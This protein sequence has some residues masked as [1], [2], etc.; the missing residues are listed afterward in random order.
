MC[1]LHAAYRKLAMQH[2]PVSESPSRVSCCGCKARH[3]CLPSLSPVAVPRGG[4]AVVRLCACKHGI[5]HMVA[6]MFDRLTCP[7]PLAVCWWLCRT[8]T[9]TTERRQKPSSKR[10]PRRTRYEPGGQAHA[11]ALESVPSPILVTS[12]FS[13]QH[14]VV[15]IFAQHNTRACQA[16]VPNC[17]LS[18]LLMPLRLG[19]VR[20]PK[21]RGV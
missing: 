5:G 21:A 14:V 20:P 19:T 10:Y 2:H 7:A 1:P 17:M 18:V 3:W 12:F 16:G 9:L 11:V 15:W 4:A 8:R 6:Q 13:S